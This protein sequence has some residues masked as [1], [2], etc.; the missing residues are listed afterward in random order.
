MNIE[1]GISPEGVD[2]VENGST[3]FSEERQK[4]GGAKKVGGKLNVTLNVKTIE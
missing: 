2:E 3:F 1:R 4:S